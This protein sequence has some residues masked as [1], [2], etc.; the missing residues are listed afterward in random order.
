M[1]SFRVIKDTYPLLLAKAQEINGSFDFHEGGDRKIMVESAVKF[2]HLKLYGF[3]T[4]FEEHPDVFPK[5]VRNLELVG[6]E[7]KS[8]KIE[9]L[10]GL[11]IRNSKP[12][13]EASIATLP[14]DLKMLECEIHTHGDFNLPRG[15]HTLGIDGFSNNS[16]F[17]LGQLDQLKF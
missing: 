16:N 3:D 4:Y 17:K 2:E 15:L 8:F 10:N 9:G 14:D 12:L 5:N 13:D 7:I 1:D 11:R 6:T